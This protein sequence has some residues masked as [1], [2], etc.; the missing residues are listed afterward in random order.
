M[1]WMVEHVMACQAAPTHGGDRPHISVTISYDALLQHAREAG[2]FTDD[3]QP[4]QARRH[5]DESSSNTDTHANH[6][7]DGADLNGDGSDD[8][9]SD[10]AEPTLFGDGWSPGVG[11]NTSTGQPVPASVLRQWLCDCDIQP[12]VLGGPSEILDVGRKHRLVTDPIR[13]GLVQRDRGCVF[14][15][16]VVPPEACHAHHIVPWACGGETA[17]SNLALLCPHHH[18]IIEPGRDPAADRWSLRLRPDGVSEI[19]PP[20]RV[21]TTQKPRVH[22]RFLTNRRT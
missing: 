1:V 8:A 16:C 4:A 21:D 22:A 5:G 7:P 14:P 2:Y 3:G 17:L 10:W 12:I 13:A 19:R 9:G 18:N 6:D 11:T 20:R 15:G